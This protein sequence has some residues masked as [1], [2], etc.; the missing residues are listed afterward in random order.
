MRDAI[1]HALAQGIPAWAFSNHD[2]AR[3]PTRIGPDNVRVAAMLLL[4]LPGPAFVYQGDE[5]GLG[6]G[7]GHDPPLDRH[8]RDGARHPMQWEPGPHGG[9]TTGEPW[10]A[11]VDPDE[12]SVAGQRGDPSSLLSLFEDL[13]GLRPE[14]GGE[15]SWVRSDPEVL[16][17][18]RGDHT[19][20]LNVTAEERP[21]PAVGQVVLA[22]H[23]DALAGGRL[24]PHAGIVARAA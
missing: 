15:L 19:V 18:R 23:E 12:R 21:A 14:L 7:P 16:A 22:T 20:A 13:I 8:G 11:T 2:R 4:T 3:L 24:A 6:D 1:E 17:Y 10:L 5:I 9:F